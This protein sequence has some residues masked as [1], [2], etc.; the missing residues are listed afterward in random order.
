MEEEGDGRPKA[1]T[2]K[3]HLGTFGEIRPMLAEAQKTK[4]FADLRLSCQDGAILVHKFVIGAQSK[5][6]RRLMTEE[7]K[8][9]ET[10]VICLPGVA[11]RTMKVVAK[12][13]YTGKLIVKHEDVEAVED[14]L[15]NVL[16][17]D[18]NIA[19]PSGGICN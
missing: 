17:I 10:T 15:R 14:L 13:L 3:V 18:A 5:Y 9:D 2:V 12:F 11:K 1:R 4:A 7:D 19:F 6:L 16:H 8:D